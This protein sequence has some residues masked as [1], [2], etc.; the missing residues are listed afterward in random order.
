MLWIAPSQNDIC[1]EALASIRASLIVDIA[2]NSNEAQYCRI[3]YPKILAKHLSEHGW[4]F[5]NKRV[6]LAVAGTNDRAYEWLYSYLI[7]SDMLTATRVLPDLKS[8]GVALPLPVAGEPY[9]ETWA[10]LNGYEV[11]Y[12]IQATYLYTNAQNAILEYTVNNIDGIPGT[13]LFA[14]AL[15]LE[16]AARLAAAIKGDSASEQKLEAKAELAWQKAIASD[17]N[18]QPQEYGNYMSEAMVA[19]HSGGVSYPNGNR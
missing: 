10:T 19:R 11:P 4:I 16:L 7:P 8:T 1:N 12:E 5:A 18:R 14:E 9:S 17:R 15:A 6:T 3:F 2:E 13:A